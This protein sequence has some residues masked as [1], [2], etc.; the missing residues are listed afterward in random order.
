[1]AMG[2]QFASIGR[3]L[4]GH[5]NGASCNGSLLNLK[6]DATCYCFGY[7]LSMANRNIFGGMLDHLDA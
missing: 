3:M 1:M 7:F 2:G 5:S 6:M 4:V